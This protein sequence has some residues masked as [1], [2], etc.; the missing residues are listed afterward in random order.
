KDRVI[1]LFEIKFYSDKLYFSPTELSKLRSRQ[2]VF[3]QTT[4]TKKFVSWVL[5]TTFGLKN[6]GGT[7][8]VLTLDDLFL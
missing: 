6:P 2:S 8:H 3:V 5:V 1:N 4:Q 7:D